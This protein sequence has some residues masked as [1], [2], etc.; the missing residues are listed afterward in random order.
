MDTKKLRQKILDLA[1]RGKLVP[2]DPNDEPASVLLE[3]IKEEKE[4]L[5]KEGK[6]KRSK[7]TTSSDTYHYRQLECV[8]FE[9]P[10]SWVWATLGDI[11]TWQAGG[12]PSR[13]NKTYYGGSIPW[14]KTGDL[15]DGLITDI[16]E[17]ITEEAV[18]NSSAKINPVGSVLIAMYG[19]TIG[20][21][22]ILTFP[23]TTNQA[24]C[25]CIE[26]YAVI[27]SYL[28]YFLLSQRTTFI[29]KGGGG[30][31]PN[32]SKEIIVNTTIPLPPLAEQQRIVTEIQRCFALINQ[33]EQRKVDLQTTIKQLKNRTLDLAIHGKLVSQ[34]PN[35]EPASKLLKR[36]NPKA[37]ITSDNEHYPYGWQYTI[38]G[39][40][41]THNTGKA[42]NSSN[43]EGMMKSYLTTSNVHWDKFDFTVLKQMPYKEN[44]LDKCTVT[45]GDLLVCEGGDIGRSAIWNY[46]Y[47][48]CIQNHI[49]KLRAKIDLCV[50]FYYY[51]LLYLKENNLIGGK[52][53]GLL[54]LSSN[55]LH[56][57]NVPLP[58]LAEQ[59]R[60][61]QKIEELF[62][63]LD[64]IQ[65]SLK[66]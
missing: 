62:S 59:Y 32:I 51:V 25:A 55:A 44:E 24:C 57:I 52:G 64:N 11:G 13:S 18:A 10:N 39:E 21:L 1:I 49:H 60:I 33:I 16:P 2:Q 5:I 56:K 41:F 58:P 30:A 66:V 6:I 29:S 23:A 46:D 50:A 43:K 54:G 17:S 63:I 20:K 19:A 47:D 14:L 53:I 38:L 27:Q 12:T 37:K 22:G 3:R 9:I 34:D 8:P 26:Y 36:I 61:V 40:I 48:I 45:K 31:Q 42:L 65:E 15:N 4:R 7:K 35:D 28:F